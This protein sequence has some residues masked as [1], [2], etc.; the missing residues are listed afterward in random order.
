[1][2]A[3]TWKCQRVAAGVKCGASNQGR[4]RKC[5]ACGKP[6]PAR[7]KPAHM[8]A[9]D[10]GYDGYLAL[11]G[12][13]HCGICKRT[14][15]QLANPARRLDR[16]HDHLT[17]RPRGLLCRECNRKLRSWL[18]REWLMAALAYLERTA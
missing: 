9:L 2:A 6:R 13:E 14:R 12:G 7:R 18:T 3:R 17:G 10:L 16:D 5:A 11:N 1:M 8:A 4:A 15:D